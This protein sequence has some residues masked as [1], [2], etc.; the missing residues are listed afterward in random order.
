MEYLQII[1][2]D[3]AIMQ[4]FLAE[5]DP[6]FVICHDYERTGD[7]EQSS[8]LAAFLAPNPE[9]AAPLKNLLIAAAIP[10][11]ASTENLPFSGAHIVAA[12]RLRKIDAFESGLCNGLHSEATAMTEDVNFGV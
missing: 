4:S 8:S 2:A 3:I 12:R 1:F 5:L 9:I 11:G 7:V 10:R 6:A